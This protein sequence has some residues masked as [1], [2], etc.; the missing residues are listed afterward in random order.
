MNAI[1][2]LPV[3]WFLIGRGRR[4]SMSGCAMGRSIMSWRRAAWPSAARPGSARGRSREAVEY[5]VGRVV[6]LVRKTATY[7]T[8]NTIVCVRPLKSV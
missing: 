2:P 6:G 1:F 7:P 4:L 8:K 3:L 5:N